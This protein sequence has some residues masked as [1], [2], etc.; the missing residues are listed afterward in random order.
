MNDWSS[1]LKG[2]VDGCQKEI[3]EAFADGLIGS[4][5]QTMLDALLNGLKPIKRYQK[6]EDGRYSV[7]CDQ[8]V[9]DWL[10]E[11]CSLPDVQRMV[12]QSTT[13]PIKKVIVE[14]ETMQLLLLKFK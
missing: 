2:Y 6:L 8:E 14:E 3:S 4:Q 13:S 10:I 7:M 9:V 5:E 1:V 12:T 11:Y